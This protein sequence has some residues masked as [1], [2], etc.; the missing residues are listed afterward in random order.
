MKC[1]VF[2]LF[3]VSSTLKEPQD[4]AHFK[5]FW[6]NFGA[7]ALQKLRQYINK[8]FELF[9]SLR[10]QSM[11]ESGWNIPDINIKRMYQNCENEKK[12]MLPSMWISN[13]W[14]TSYKLPVMSCYLLHALR[15]AFYIRVTS[16]YLLHEL[17]ITFHIR[18]T[19]YYLLHELQVNFYVEGTS[20]YLSHELGL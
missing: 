5:D 18:V 8:Y 16:Y 17:R 4:T 10:L 19:S 3:I 9:F 14:V 15:V 20:Y 7:A 1:M 12:M 2:G 6:S 11:L 13:K